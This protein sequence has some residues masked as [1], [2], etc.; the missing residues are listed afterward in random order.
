MRRVAP[1]PEDGEIGVYHGWMMT[2][3]QYEALFDA[4]ADRRVTLVNTPE[5]YEHCH[6]L[7]RW[8]KTLAGHTPRS[9]WAQAGDTSLPRL[10]VLIKEFSDH[11]VIVKDFV[12]SRKHEWLDA[13]FI[14]SAADA[15]AVAQVTGKFLELQ[16][17]ELSGGLVLREF[18]EFELLGSHAKSGMPLT[19]EFRLFFLD[20]Q[21]V[22]VSK[23]WDQGN[24]AGETPPLEHFTR[25]AANVESRF[26]TMDVAKTKHGEWLVV[27]LGDA[28]VSELPEDAALEGIFG[29]LNEAIK[30]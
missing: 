30:V 6:Y 12:K 22:Q 8:Y 20:G 3:Q 29:K 25:L 24:Y 7:P 10:M 23:Y 5:Q 27:E 17:D 15:E 19:W 13:C 28:Q 18:V 26:F 14:P 2:T 4:L 9:V 11:P 16:G 21:P 1:A